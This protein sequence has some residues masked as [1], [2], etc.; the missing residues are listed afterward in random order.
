MASLTA[1][2]FMEGIT[3]CYAPAWK[4]SEGE[5][6]GDKC[7]QDIRCYSMSTGKFQLQT[8]YSNATHSCGP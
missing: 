3:D 2:E 7:T 1:H 5:E 4:D 8:E 6:I